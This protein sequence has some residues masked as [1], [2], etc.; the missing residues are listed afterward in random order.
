MIKKV[1]K[2]LMG[3]KVVK[4]RGQQ[5]GRSLSFCIGGINKKLNS[6]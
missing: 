3:I 1:K 2:A 4:T 5:N 6:R